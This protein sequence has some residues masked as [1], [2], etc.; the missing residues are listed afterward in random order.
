MAIALLINTAPYGTEGPFNALRLARALQVEEERVELL[1]M[2]DAVN[3]ARRGQ[4]PRTAHAALEPLLAELI[5]G[6]ASVTL[7]GTCCETRGLKEGD[8]ITGV[9]VGT[10]HDFARVVK[11][12]EK[13]VSF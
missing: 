8:L 12:S 3:T 7:C 5:E 13:V 1:L 4:E 10:I 9:V 6:G 2:G 11:R